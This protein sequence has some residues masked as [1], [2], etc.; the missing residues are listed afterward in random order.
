MSIEGASESTT[1]AFFW[2]GRW[3][4]SGTKAMSS[5]FVAVARRRWSSPRKL[6]PSSPVT[7]TSDRSYRP[8][9]RS[10]RRIRP[11]ERSA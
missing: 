3:T 6:S 7:I 2:P 5:V 8:A 4:K 1:R 11:S 9:W 10:L